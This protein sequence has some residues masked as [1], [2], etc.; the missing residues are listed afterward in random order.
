MHRSEVPIAVSSP[1]GDR[2]SS[3][4]R[5]LVAL[6]TVLAM[7]LGVGVASIAPASATVGVDWSVQTPAESNW[8][9]SVAYGNGV[10]VAVSSGGT[11]QAMTS[12]DGAT[13]TAQTAPSGSWE[14]LTFGNGLFVAVAGN[15]TNR[16][17][18]S[19]DGVTWTARSVEQSAWAGVTYGNGLF[20]AVAYS[21]S[22]RV[23]TSPDGVTWT[24]RSVEQNDLSDVAY[25]NGLFVAVGS[26]G[27]NRVVTSPDGVNWTGRSA[28]E[29]N[30]WTGVG[31]GN[32]LFVAVAMTGTNRVMTS[33]DGET[34]T[35]QSVEQNQWLTVTYGNG[36]FVAVA[37]NG[38]NRVMT[39]PDGETWTMRSVPATMWTSVTYARGLFV[40]VGGYTGP[41]T[42]RVLNSGALEPATVPAAPTSLVATPGNGSA[43]IAFTAGD[44]GG[45]AITKY[46]YSTNDG[47]TWSDAASGTTSPVF[48]NGLTNGTSYSIKLRAYNSVGG[49]AASTAVS[50]TPSTVPSAPSSLVANPGD[51][52]ASI[53]FTPGSDG[54]AAITKYQYK[55]GAGAWTD[56]VGTTSPITITGLTN[57]VT[58]SVK[59]RAVNV[60]GAGAA[61][62]AVSVR[63]KVAG[64]AIGVAYSSGKNG[65]FVG[66]TFARPAGST[67]VGFTVRAYAKGTNTVVSSC[68]VLPNSR[69]CYVGS[70]TSGTE[71]DIRVQGYLR[72]SGSSTVRETFESAPSRVRINS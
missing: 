70:L 55:V 23:M 62:A 6:V 58:S 71:Y 25:G 67:L 60:A 30:I 37:M 52:S 44:S 46:Q 64:P 54:G 24:T 36:L 19:P 69:N 48:I 11:H 61:S 68:Q 33:P 38:T 21:G 13:W 42:D 5:R 41:G 32:G 16:L 59:I 39:S 34:W 12:P 27:T 9:N 50:V 1:I 7:I 63:P 8:W 4:S 66:F 47:G 51:G 29:A 3:L 53:A 56:A 40:A 35:A 65:A 72:V 57:Y 10:F 17:M 22:S 49:G 43:S 28:T 2:G 45:A 15:G 31:F 14:A 20:V 18:T 26:G